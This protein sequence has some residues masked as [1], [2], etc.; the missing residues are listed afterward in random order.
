MQHPFNRPWLLVRA[1]FAGAVLLL[2]GCSTPIGVEEVPT[3]Q[4]YL[5]VQGNA[6]STGK[7]SAATT[8]ILDRYELGKVAAKAPEDAVRQLHARAVATGDRDLLFALAEL[9]Y[10]AGDRLRA[11]AV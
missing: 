9:S 4:A 11:G 3:Q 2:A 7:P 1:S 10:L 8:A 6:L 5:Q